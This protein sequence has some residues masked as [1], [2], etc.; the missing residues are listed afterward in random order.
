MSTYPARAAMPLWLAF[1]VLLG[2]TSR[3][4]FPLRRVALAGSIALAG[5]V[6]MAAPITIAESKIASVPGPSDSEPQKETLMIYADARQKQ[7]EWV[8]APTV[9]EGYKKNVEWGL[10]AFNN[11]VA[12]EGFIYFNVG[13]GFVDPLTGILSGWA[14]GCSSSGW[15]VAGPTRAFR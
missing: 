4:S 7:R 10:G 11:K 5:F 13:H 9:W 8:S 14:S 3:R 2:L 15:S 12:D 1:L 6:L